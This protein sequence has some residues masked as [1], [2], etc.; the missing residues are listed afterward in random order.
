[1]KLK[2]QMLHISCT[3]IRVS[4]DRAPCGN[5]K[6]DPGERAWKKNNSYEMKTVKKNKQMSV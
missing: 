5:Q 6:H 4:T 1:M 3:Q 2:S